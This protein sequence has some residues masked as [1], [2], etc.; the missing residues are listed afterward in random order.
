MWLKPKKKRQGPP[1]AK[2]NDQLNVQMLL[3]ITKI[4]YFT[5][6]GG[7]FLDIVQLHKT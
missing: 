7:T 6:K 1:P 5:I 3:H 4:M 2:Y